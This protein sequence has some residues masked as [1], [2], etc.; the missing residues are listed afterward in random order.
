MASSRARHVPGRPACCLLSFQAYLFAETL[1]N[2]ILRRHDE[3]NLSGSGRLMR[4][5]YALAVIALGSA[6]ALADGVREARWCLYDATMSFAEKGKSG[7]GNICWDTFRFYPRETER[8]VTV[9]AIVDAC[10]GNE[11]SAIKN[12]HHCQ[13]H[14]ENAR[15]NIDRDRSQVINWLREEGN[16]RGLC[17]PQPPTTVPQPPRPAEVFRPRH[18]FE[19]GPSW[20]ALYALNPNEARYACAYRYQFS[21]VSFGERIV[22]DVNRPAVAYLQPASKG[23]RQLI[24]RSSGYYIDVLPVGTPDIECVPQ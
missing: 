6:P 2:S 11:N 19:Y 4:R 18:E 23:Q 5:L 13:C 21:Y 3:G 7:G 15:N 22:Q 20:I 1:R 24:S 17:N 16:R 12:L 9:K 14:N 10:T 8:S